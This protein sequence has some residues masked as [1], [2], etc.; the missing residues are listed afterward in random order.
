MNNCGDEIFD[1]T[2]YN[3]WEKNGNSHACTQ[4]RECVESCA[5]V[6]M[7][8]KWELKRLHL[9]VPNEKLCARED[10][11]FKVPMK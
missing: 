7:I 1:S 2:L 8:V 5:I 6:G 3:E 9:S 11:I 10:V 4:N